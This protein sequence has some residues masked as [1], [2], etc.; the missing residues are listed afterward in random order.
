MAFQT[1]S[2]HYFYSTLPTS[3]LRIPVQIGAGDVGVYFLRESVRD[4]GE[5]SAV[6]CWVDDNYGGAAVLENAASELGAGETRE[7]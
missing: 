6:S 7:T 5:G 1:S 3:K 4:V 2:A